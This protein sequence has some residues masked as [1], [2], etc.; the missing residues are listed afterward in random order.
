MTISLKK[1]MGLQEL[2]IIADVGVVFSQDRR[3]KIGLLE[4][5]KWGGSACG[6]PQTSATTIVVAQNTDNLFRSL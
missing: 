3:G 5:Q 6:L 2:S 4:Y 1:G